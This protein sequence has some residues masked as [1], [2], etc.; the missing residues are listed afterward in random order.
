MLTPYPLTIQLG[1]KRFHGHVFL[2]RDRLYFVCAKQGGAWAAAIGQ[3]VGGLVGAAIASAATGGPGQAPQGA[4][5]E[6]TLERAVAEHDGSLI[7]DAAKLEEIK[8]TMW[9]RIIRFDGKKYGLP[10]GLGK[11]LKQ[12]LGSWARQ[13]NVKTKGLPA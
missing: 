2:G 13:N 3:S 10:R 6:P 8:E 12:A 9:W 1:M 5:D 11:D 4:F 7:M